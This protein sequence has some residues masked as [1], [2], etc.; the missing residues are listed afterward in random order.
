[1]QDLARDAAE[2]DASDAAATVAADRDQVGPRVGRRG[3][4]PVGRPAVDEPGAGIG[5][6]AGSAA[7]RLGGLGALVHAAGDPH[8][9]EAG[10]AGEAFL[11]DG[12]RDEPAASPTSTT[13][14]FGRTGPK[15]RPRR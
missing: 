9:L 13:T 10:M 6:S 4:Q 15:V 7:A 3:E 8:R 14:S 12:D 2:D 1:M 11:T 5:S